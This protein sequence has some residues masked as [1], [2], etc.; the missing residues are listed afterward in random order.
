MNE[1]ATLEGQEFCIRVFFFSYEPFCM[2][3]KDRKKNVPR[4]GGE[5]GITVEE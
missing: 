1:G 5:G 3:E 2:E 4:K